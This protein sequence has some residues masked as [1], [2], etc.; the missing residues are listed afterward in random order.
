MIMVSTVRLVPSQLAS[1]LASLTLI[2]MLFAAGCAGGAPKPIATGATLH[3]TDDVN[4]NGQ[5][6]PSP[7][8]VRIFRLSAVEAFRSA[9]IVNLQGDE[10]ALLAGDLTG[11]VLSQLLRPGQTVALDLSYA[12]DTAYLGVVA[13]FIA[14]DAEWRTVVAIPE[15]GPFS[16]VRRPD[17]TVTVSA[18]AVAASFE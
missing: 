16:A 8:M 7:V 13:E 15:E 10:P 11:P 18:A 4:P 14:P 1:L 5:G 6:R 12:P 17:L 3:G 9:G 2:G